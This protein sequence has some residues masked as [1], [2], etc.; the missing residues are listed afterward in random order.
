MS[1]KITLRLSGLYTFFVCYADKKL[2]APKESFG[3]R[4]LRRR[5]GRGAL[6][7]ANDILFCVLFGLALFRE[8]ILIPLT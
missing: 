3:Q 8:L 7:A 4:A 6:M 2:T 5:R 1:L